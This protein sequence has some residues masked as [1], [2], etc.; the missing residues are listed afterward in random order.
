MNFN[1]PEE[2]TKYVNAATNV[3]MGVDDVVRAFKDMPRRPA[4]QKYVNK[5]MGIKETGPLEEYLREVGYIND[6][7]EDTE[8]EEEK[9]PEEK[10]AESMIGEA[11][12]DE[13]AA[14]VQQLKVVPYAEEGKPYKVGDVVGED[15]IFDADDYDRMGFRP[16]V[17]EQ[18]RVTSVL[19]DSGERLYVRNGQ[20][21]P[22]LQV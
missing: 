6:R 22:S 20:F 18:G 14:P 2:I 3:I 17:D 16:T 13:P 15:L 5:Q 12:Q 1:N 10:T 21:Y 4:F 9:T 11:V 19:T 7:F 8:K